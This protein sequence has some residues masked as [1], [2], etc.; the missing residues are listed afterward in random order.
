M[1]FE[2]AA[3]LVAT[4]TASRS[5]DARL[6]RLARDMA[7]AYAIPLSR[8]AYQLRVALGRGLGITLPREDDR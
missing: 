4:R 6:Q 3:A 1:E 5:F 8:A 7:T 2:R